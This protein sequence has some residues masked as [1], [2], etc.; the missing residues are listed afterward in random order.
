MWHIYLYLIH[1][2]FKQYILA[3]FAE[4][5]DVWMDLLQ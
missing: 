5:F 2:Y 1:Q 3:Q 4:Q